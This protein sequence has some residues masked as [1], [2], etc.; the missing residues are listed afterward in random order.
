[1]AGTTADLTIRLKALVD[2]SFKKLKDDID[3][4]QNKPVKAPKQKLTPADWSLAADN[5]E[6]LSDKALNALRQPIDDFREFET[7]MAQVEG[8]MGKDTSALETLRRA[9]LE[10]G[11]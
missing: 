8:Q 6:K 2:D 7:V 1:M 3:T 9:A 5:L 4:L 10:M 11:K